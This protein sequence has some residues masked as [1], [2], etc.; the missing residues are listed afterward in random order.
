MCIID[1][2][3]RLKSEKVVDSFV[4]FARI[5]D[6]VVAPM[7]LGEV[8]DEAVARFIPDMETRSIRRTV[9]RE[10]DLT[11]SGDKEK[12]LEVFV[13]VLQN[14]IDAMRDVGA[15]ELGVRIAGRGR[16]IRATVRDTGDVVDESSLT[17]IFEPSFRTRD[18][19]L[20]LGM[21]VA[22]TFVESHGGSISAALAQ[23]GGCVVTIDLPRRGVG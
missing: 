17:N 1:F 21:T 3:A 2:R 7:D 11:C 6:M 15:G 19:A 20:G 12:I 14:A 22:R 9:S 23:G 10:G 18:T 8:M 16:S 4:K 13:A 5:R